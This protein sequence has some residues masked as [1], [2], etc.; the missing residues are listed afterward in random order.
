MQ[1]I[2]SLYVAIGDVPHANY[3]VKRVENYYLLHRTQAPASL[4]VQHAWLLYN[5]NDDA[6]LYPVLTRLD[7]RQDLTADQRQQVQTLWA[8]LGRSPRQPGDGHGALFAR[9]PDP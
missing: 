1:G 2:A 9:R 3:Y 8:D 4:E 6:G 5:I 7:A